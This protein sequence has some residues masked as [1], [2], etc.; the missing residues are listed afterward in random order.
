LSVSNLPMMKKRL[1]QLEADGR[2]QQELI[3]ADKAHQIRQHVTLLSH[4]MKCGVRRLTLSD[5]KLQPISA[6]EGM[7][8]VATLNSNGHADY[9]LE[10]R[11][12]S[13][14]AD[15]SMANLTALILSLNQLGRF[16][17]P[18]NMTIRPEGNDGHLMLTVD[19][20]LL[21]LVESFD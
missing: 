6:D 17:I 7:F 16:A 5:P 8:P 21:N 20:S 15:G 9:S 12:L 3:D 13:L 10:I 2:K 18:T 19:I 11:T 1:Q 4:Q 14:S